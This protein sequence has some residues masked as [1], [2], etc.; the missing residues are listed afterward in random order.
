MALV[1]GSGWL[2]AAE[3]LGEADGRDRHHRPARLLRRRG[4]RATPARSAR[5]G[6]ATAACWSSSAAPT[7]TRA[8]ASRPS[9]TACGPRPRP[10]AARSCSPTAAAGSRR[11]GRRDAGADQ[12]PHQPHRPLAD[13]G[14][15]LRRPHRPLQL[16]AAR[17]VPRGRPEPR[18][19]RLRAVPRAAL[20][21]PGRGRHGRRPR[22]PPGRHEHHA[23]GDRRPRGR[24]WR[25]S[26]S[27]W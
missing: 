25:S 1:L 16:P 11:A 23:R 7:T 20:R 5:S 10:A 9:C 15:E 2:P 13:R 26:A 17:A 19:G 22:R 24:A 3:L 14:R 8:R 18:R 4:R 21:D 6:P 12:R 27:A